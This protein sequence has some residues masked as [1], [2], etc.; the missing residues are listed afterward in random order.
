[1]SIIRA[2]ADAPEATPAYTSVKVQESSSCSLFTELGRALDEYAYTLGA[3]APPEALFY[4]QEDTVWGDFSTAF[5]FT[6]SEALGQAP[7]TLI[8]KF[9]PL[10]SHELQSEV[11]TDKGYLN[12]QLSVAGWN[13]QRTFGDSRGT[14]HVVLPPPPGELNRWEYLRIVLTGIVQALRGAAVGFTATVQFPSGAKAWSFSPLRPP[15]VAV[16]KEMLEEIVA[17]PIQG[18][19]DSRR[20]ADAAHQM[21][22]THGTAW[23]TPTTLGKSDFRTLL[24]D[25]RQ[26]RKIVRCADPRWCQGIKSTRRPESILHLS[27][28]QLEA[29]SLYASSP[30][31]A[32]DWDAYVPEFQEKAN[33]SWYWEAGAQRL[34][35]I[36]SR[37]RESLPHSTKELYHEVSEAQW[38][39]RRYNQTS[40]VQRLEVQSAVSQGAVSQGAG[41]F[42]R[43]E[44]AFAKVYAARWWAAAH[45]MIFLPHQ[46]ESAA[47][48][49]LMSGLNSGVVRQFLA[50]LEHGALEGPVSPQKALYQ[51]ELTL[52]SPPVKLEG[53]DT[54]T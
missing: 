16:L 15:S 42:Q 6:L 31:L 32:F 20:Y 8:E 21:N 44:R 14:L 46:I 50:N 36:R 2:P 10:L 9:L 11:R 45:G 12:V 38:L 3:S 33:L 24:T 43:V 30:T 52:A 26:Q 37:F 5:F 49:Q 17:A 7:D 25:L 1:M 35:E 34:R 39:E 22:A 19:S 47:L 40:E 54:I 13:L 48:G 28:L 18:P 4:P 27:A 29:L 41:Q 53:G 51:I 23:L